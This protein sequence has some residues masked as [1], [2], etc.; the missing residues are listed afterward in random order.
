[1]MGAIM[2]TQTRLLETLAKPKIGKLSN[3][4]EVRIEIE[5]A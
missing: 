5:G 2:E 1:M 4:K 3:G